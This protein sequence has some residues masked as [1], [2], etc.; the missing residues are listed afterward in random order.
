MSELHASPMLISKYSVVYEEM[1]KKA[2]EI[3]C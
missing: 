3:W 2:E 1:I